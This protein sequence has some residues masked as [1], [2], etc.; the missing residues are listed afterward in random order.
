MTEKKEFTNCP[1]CK[2]HCPVDAL[3]CSRGQSH[4]DAYLAGGEKKNAGSDRMEIQIM[5]LFQKYTHLV[6]N[7][8]GNYEGKGLVLSVILRKGDMTQRRLQAFADIRSSSMSEILAKLESDGYISRE[9]S[10]NDKRNID[11][12][13][14]EKGRIAAEEYEQEQQQL[15]DQLYSGL[16]NREKQQ[17]AGILNKLVG[18]IKISTDKELEVKNR[19]DEHPDGHQA[20]SGLLRGNSEGV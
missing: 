3:I 19:M 5:Q 14:T 1:L 13:L 15:A 2:R 18:S 6:R 11:I 7:R 8:K 12:S 20:D 16:T 9:K 4:A 17:L 10:D